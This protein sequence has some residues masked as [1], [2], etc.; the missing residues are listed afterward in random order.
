MQ[1]T[2]ADD[3]TYVQ[4]WDTVAMGERFSAHVMTRDV[5]A[6]LE[7]LHPS[8][9]FVTAQYFAARERLG[10]EVWVAGVRGYGSDLSFG[11]GLFFKQGLMNLELEIVS[12]PSIASDSVFW[13]GL[14]QLCAHRA[15]TQLTLDTYGSPAGTTIPVLA[16]HELRRARTEYV[17]DLRDDFEARMSPE[18]RTAVD[19]ARR[20]GMTTVR[21]RSLEALRSHLSIVNLPVIERGETAEHPTRLSDKIALLDSE[22]GEL[23]QALLNGKVLASTLMMHSATGA[24]YQSGGNAPSN[25]SSDAAHFLLHTT[26]LEL[27]AEG[28]MCVSLGGALDGSAPAKFRLG[29]GA[30]PRQLEASICDVGSTWKRRATQALALARFS[31]L[32]LRRMIGF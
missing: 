23:V 3:I 30:T 9:P 10:F 4:P 2:I 15:V 17:V 20:Q 16:T 31:P 14:L 21:R 32:R 5:I 28:I 18:H 29:F 1:L 8:N 27:R 13:P 25:E 19:R 11:C 7:A 12:L 26:L 22:A 24:F 6:E